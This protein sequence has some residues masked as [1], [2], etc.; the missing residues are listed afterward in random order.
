MN[1]DRLTRR[2]VLVG[3]GSAAVAA[4]LAGCGSSKA[5]PVVEPKP[6]ATPS[7]ASPTPTVSSTP[8]SDAALRRKIASLLI[9]GFRGTSVTSSDWIVRA[10]ADQ[11]LGVVIL[12]N[13]DQQTKG[14]RNITSPAQV[15]S[16]I[17][18]LRNAA[19]GP[20][21]VSIDQEGGQVSRLNPSD[22]FPATRSEADIGA[23]HSMTATRTWATGI[24]NTL[25][26]VG[27]N[28][29][30]APVV[31][32]NVNPR[33]P[34]IGALGR[35]FSAS[36]D[37][38]VANATVEIAA[39][40]AAGV[41]TVLKHFPGFGSATGNTD[42]GVVDVSKTWKPIELQPFQKLIAAGTAQ[43]ILLAHLLNTQLDPKL[44]ASLSHTV[45][46]G[47]LRG[48]LGWKGPIVSDDMQA[49]A[50]TSKFGRAEATTLALE[51]GLDLL[52]FANQETYNTKIVDQTIDTVV[53]LVHAGH[54][55]EADIDA[56]VA[57]VNTLRPPS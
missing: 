20:L 19:P 1:D 40:K 51:A 30:F 17:R 9:V 45:V 13:V 5:K 57:R 10:I 11:G 23:A 26:S 49:V 54:L 12:F 16:L 6:S 42:F 38:V 27:V 18:T 53:G 28:L 7:S 37:V 48:Q 35:S 21:I 4:G 39:H 31:D 29:N 32:L 36:P 25:R 33:N 47:L 43:C 46:T 14:R 2:R 22:G 44:P 52:V 41:R 24:A 3:L 15:T 55:T 56:K 34:A 8:Q 50:I